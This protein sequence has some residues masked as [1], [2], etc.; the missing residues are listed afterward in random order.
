MDAAAQAI[1]ARVLRDGPAESIAVMTNM[2]H[3]PA[4]AAFRT[5]FLA[6]VQPGGRTITCVQSISS[7][8]GRQAFSLFRGRAP[9]VIVTTCEEMA[10]AAVRAGAL[11]GCRPRIYT[12]APKRLMRPTQYAAY[13]LNYRRLGYAIGR[14]LT[15]EG[16]EKRPL[17]GDM[18]G[19]AP[20][21]FPR[22]GAVRRRRLSLL[23]ADTP[24]SAR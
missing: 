15:C 24:W 5:A 6:S 4:E 16:E 17:I 9:E 13:Q 11:L 12:L 7:Q 21:P 22:S 1:A 19:F 2:V 8:Y 20:E 18:S 14:M 10:M 23:T 3:Y